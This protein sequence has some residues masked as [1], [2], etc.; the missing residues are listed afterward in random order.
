MLTAEKALQELAD[1]FAQARDLAKRRASA[2][3][4]ALI[5]HERDIESEA[6]EHAREMVESYRTDLGNRAERS[7]WARAVDNAKG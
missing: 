2:A 1:Y 7:S 4:S 5:A 6:F 3:G